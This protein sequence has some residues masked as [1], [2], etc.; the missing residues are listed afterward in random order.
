MVQQERRLCS[1]KTLNPLPYI[2]LPSDNGGI[3]LDVSEQGLRF[4]AHGPVEQ[5][6]PIIFWFTAHSNLIAGIGELVWTDQGR[7]TGGLRFTQLAHNCREQ[8]RGWPYESNLR[9]GVS[10]DLSLHIPAAEALTPSG[11][12]E[13]AASEPSASDAAPP[14]DSPRPEQ[15]GAI[16][17]ESHLPGPGGG[18]AESYALLSETYFKR[19][20][21]N[22]YKVAGAL[23]LIAII[24]I[25]SYIHYRGSREH[26]ETRIS[27]EATPQALTQTPGSNVLPSA[28]LAGDAAADQSK[29]EGTQVQAA[30]QSAKTPVQET[31]KKNAVGPAVPHAPVSHARLR[32]PASSGTEIAVQVAALT[33]EQ[34]ARKLA[35]GLRNKNF[36]ASVRTF[37][38]DSLYRVMLGP[39]GDEESARAAIGKLKQA[40][41][42][43][44]IRRVPVAEWPRS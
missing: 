15:F 2:N 28:P 13:L 43:A 14:F 34:D 11:P 4:R 39:F 22:R 40:G 9:T 5:S 32:K 38:D 19:Q 6:G 36:Q 8:I 26:Q 23:F 3:I 35:D 7:K 12:N 33:H 20:K 31:T 21:H 27:G 16:L 10:N 1:R 25:F 24:S 29:M 42:S 41:F 44:F 37:P 17:E 30:P 18:I